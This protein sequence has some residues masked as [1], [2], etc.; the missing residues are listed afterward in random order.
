MIRVRM[1]ALSGTCRSGETFHDC[2]KI[3]TIGLPAVLPRE[4]LNVLIRE[5]IE[6]H[7][8]G[9]IENGLSIPR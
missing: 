4:E 5:A 7:I 1:T 8:E 3:L 9:M 6:L 2:Q